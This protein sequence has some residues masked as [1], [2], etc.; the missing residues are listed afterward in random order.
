L[1]PIPPHPPSVYSS[2]EPTS[3]V[4][5]AAQVDIARNEPEEDIWVFA[6][7]ITWQAITAPR[8]Y[9]LNALL[10]HIFGDQPTDVVACDAC[11]VRSNRG[12]FTFCRSAVGF[13]GGACS[14]C[15]WRGDGDSCTLQDTGESGES[16]ES[17]D[18]DNEGMVQEEAEEAGEDGDE[19]GEDGEGDG[20]GGEEDGE[21]GEGDGE[22]S[23]GDGGIVIGSLDSESDEE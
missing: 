6:H 23:E 5:Q 3:G 1:K 13:W 10:I 20:E 4:R 22:D 14:N 17:D 2:H 11:V 21:D 7:R 19:G 16:G 8:D 12:P 18:S 9:R 15:E